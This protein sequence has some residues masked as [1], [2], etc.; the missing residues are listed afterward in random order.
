MTPAMAP[1]SGRALE[2]F[3]VAFFWMIAAYALGYRRSFAGV[4]EGGKPPRKQPVAR[5]A[6]AFLD[7][8]SSR[9]AAFDRACH[10]FILRAMLR[11]EAHRMC[12]SVA[13]GLGWLLAAQQASSSNRETRLEAPFTVAYL[14]TSRSANR[15]RAS[16]GRTAE[17]DL[18]GLAR[19]AGQ[20]GIWRPAARDSQFSSPR[21]AR[22][23]VRS[24]MARHGTPCGRAAHRGCARALDLSR[25]NSARRISQRFRSRVRCRRSAI[26]SSRYA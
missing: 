1:F 23:G 24:G 15:L 3:A 20:P 19:S 14:L 7:L 10:R 22:P 18:P 26:I 17:L 6:L 9:A 13:I 25:R 12:I 8:F 4:L 16:G 2:G 21:G 11:S 5:L